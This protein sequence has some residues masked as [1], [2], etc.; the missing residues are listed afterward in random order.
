VALSQHRYK[1]SSYITK[2]LRK[3]YIPLQEIPKRLVC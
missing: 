3:T 1:S 2:Q